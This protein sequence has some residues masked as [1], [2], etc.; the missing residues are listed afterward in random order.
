ML[1]TELKNELIELFQTTKN[2]VQKNGV[3]KNELI[4]INHQKPLDEFSIKQRNYP[5][6]NEIEVIVPLTRFQYKKTFSNKD[7]LIRYLKIHLI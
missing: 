6:T 1:N 2:W 4:F 5:Y 3:Q 7:E